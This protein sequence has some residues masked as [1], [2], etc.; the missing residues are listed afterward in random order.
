MKRSWGK[1]KEVPGKL[2]RGRKYT[3]RKMRK[4]RKCK[5]NGKGE[6]RKSYLGFKPEK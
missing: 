5:L 6:G 4:Q 3:R 1:Q 2:K